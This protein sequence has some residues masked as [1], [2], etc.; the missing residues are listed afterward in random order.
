M[1]IISYFILLQNH[2]NGGELNGIVKQDFTR[3]DP[4]GRW[5]GTEGEFVWMSWSSGHM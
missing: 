1:P 2:W 5:E 4:N 3:W